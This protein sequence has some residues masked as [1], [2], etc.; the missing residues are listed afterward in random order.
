MSRMIPMAR[1]RTTSNVETRLD[2]RA[3]AD[4]DDDCVRR[5][6]V[7]IEHKNSRDLAEIARLIGRLA[8]PIE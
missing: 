6:A 3:F 7:L 4:S 8:V 2:E 1:R 5:L